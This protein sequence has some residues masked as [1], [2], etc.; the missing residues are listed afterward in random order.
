MICAPAAKRQASAWVSGAEG[1]ERREDGA[2]D[3]P[4]RRANSESVSAQSPR[5]AAASPS[6]ALDALSRITFAQLPDHSPEAVGFSAL[7]YLE[8]R[9]SVKLLVGPLQPVCDN[10]A[11]DDIRKRV[12]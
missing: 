1:R 7:D 8:R 4:P 3:H 5:G 10:A 2:D 12:K 6:L 9:R 11:L